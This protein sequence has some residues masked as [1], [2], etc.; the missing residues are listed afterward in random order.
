MSWRR[1]ITIGALHQ[2]SGHHDKE[3]SITLQALAHL[4]IATL[5]DSF[6]GLASAFVLGP[7]VGFER[8]ARQRA[9]G[10]RTNALVAVAASVFVDMAAQI[11]TASDATRVV[12]YVVPGVGFLGA[13]TIM[14]EGLSVRGLN[15]AAT[16]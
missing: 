7:L 4:N 16:F 6:I 2:N 3:P 1:T 14:K 5:V 15:T 12:A 9:V 10:L 11:G 13:D 8:Q